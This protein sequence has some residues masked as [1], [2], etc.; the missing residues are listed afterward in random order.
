MWKILNTARTGKL[1][2]IAPKRI[3]AGSMAKILIRKILSPMANDFSLGST[4]LYNNSLKLKTFCITRFQVSI[5][6]IVVVVQLQK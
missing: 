4:H 3:G 5:A 2:K 6:V 1:P